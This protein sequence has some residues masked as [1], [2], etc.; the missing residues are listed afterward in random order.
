M[1]EEMQSK[2][3][4]MLTALQ[5]EMV[6]G[7][8]FAKEQ[9]PLVMQEMLRWG[10]VKQCIEGGVALVLLSVFIIGFIKLWRL[11]NKTK[12][13]EIKESSQIFIGIIFFISFLCL[14][15]LITAINTMV[16]IKVAP[17]V[18]LIEQVQNLINK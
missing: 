11:Q 15:I 9:F 3:V 7:V 17:R 4:E 8:A 12:D 10:F 2:I 16:K 13:Q 18:Y 6:S 5:S 1:N 14:C